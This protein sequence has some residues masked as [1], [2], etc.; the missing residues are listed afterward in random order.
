MLTDTGIAWY[1]RCHICWR[2]GAIFVHFWHESPSN[3]NCGWRWQ[4][5]WLRKCSKIRV[6][7]VCCWLRVI[8]SWFFLTFFPTFYSV[9]DSTYFSK[10]GRF[11]HLELSEMEFDLATL[12]ITLVSC[13]FRSDPL[14]AWRTGLS[15]Q[16]GFVTQQLQSLRLN[17]IIS[18][19][20]TPRW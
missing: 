2:R 3:Y 17:G 12:E 8:F 15:R 9:N 5:C 1:L 14:R 18:T 11:V 7:G 6:S 20:L 13:P 19:S 10:F 4:D 16:H